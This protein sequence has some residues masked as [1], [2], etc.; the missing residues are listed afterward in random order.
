[1]I[2][3]L[4][5]AANLKQYPNKVVTKDKEFGGGDDP[6]FRAAKCHMDKCGTFGP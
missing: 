6:F 4:C 5:V 3:A 1:M 2:Y